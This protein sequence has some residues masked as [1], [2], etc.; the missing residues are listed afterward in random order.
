MIVVYP[1]NNLWI[2]GINGSLGAPEKKFSI[3]SSK[4]KTNFACIYI[5]VMII[6]VCLLTKKTYKFK[7]D[8]K[9]VG[10]PTQFCLRSISNTFNFM[11]PYRSIFTMDCMIFQLI[12][13]L[14]I[15][16]TN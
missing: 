12:A 10:F 14:L 15:N 5:T 2:F 7:A 1:E 9:N 6:V 3:T 11:E 13:M 8:N 16:L 4:A